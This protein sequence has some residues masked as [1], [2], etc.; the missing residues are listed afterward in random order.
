MLQLELVTPYD[1]RRVFDGKGK[2]ARK[3]SQCRPSGVSEC[4]YNRGLGG[5]F[6]YVLF[7]PLFGE[8]SHFEYFSK[9]LKPPTRGN[10]LVNPEAFCESLQ[11][12]IGHPKPYATNLQPRSL[13]G[14]NGRER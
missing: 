8:D 6:K 10:L 5:G 13:A 4:L 9:G 1:M 2:P 14:A 3:S 12:K 11:L 7:S